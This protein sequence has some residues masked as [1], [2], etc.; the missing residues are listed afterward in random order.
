[1]GASHNLGNAIVEPGWGSLWRV[2]RAIKSL[3]LEADARPAPFERLARQRRKPSELHD[4]FLRK[5]RW[6]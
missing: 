6:S 5:V 2:S 3:A 1:M 4:A